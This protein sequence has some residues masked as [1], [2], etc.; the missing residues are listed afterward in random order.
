MLLLA[1]GMALHQSLDHA[2]AEDENT[3]QQEQAFKS[4]QM[5]LKRAELVRLLAA[6]HL[7]YISSQ[8]K[9]NDI[10]LMDDASQVMAFGLVCDD[11]SLDPAMMNKI[12]AETTLQIALA[13]NGSPIEDRITQVMGELA[14]TERLTLVAD[15]ST[16]VLMFKVGRRRGLFDALLTD[17]G[18]DR[19][20]K[21]M[22]TNM[23]ARYNGLAAYLEEQTQ[24]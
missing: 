3:N 13:V 12:A 14:P 11:P 17:F 24:E 9:K 23:I 1:V 15:V 22:R 4:M 21:G 19:F 16:T 8:R 7:I 20:C 5:M 2:A 18:T 10:H 6:E